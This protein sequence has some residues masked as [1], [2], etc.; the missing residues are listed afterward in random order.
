MPCGG[1]ETICLPS[2]GDGVRLCSENK[3]LAVYKGQFADFIGDEA[4]L[5]FRGQRGVKG[6]FSF[7]VIKKR[8]IPFDPKEKKH[9]FSFV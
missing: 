8:N 9:T 4:L 5:L 7:F 1:L 3:R 2:A 6:Y